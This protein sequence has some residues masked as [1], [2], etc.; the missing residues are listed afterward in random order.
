[1]IQTFGNRSHQILHC[2]QTRRLLRRSSQLAKDKLLQNGS[3]CDIC[4]TAFLWLDN[5]HATSA[6]DPRSF[7]ISG[8]DW[9]HPTS[10]L[11]CCRSTLIL[12]RFVEAPSVGLRYSVICFAPDVA[13]HLIVDLDA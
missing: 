7:H 8:H 13:V 12:D 9:V 10:A 4:Y 3:T 6:T 5:G 1:M 2:Q 11:V